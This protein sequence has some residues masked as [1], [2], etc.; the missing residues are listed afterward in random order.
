MQEYKKL[1]EDLYNGNIKPSEEKINSEEYAKVR[2]ESIELSNKILNGLN[3]QNKDIYYKYIELQS[4]LQSMDSEK[5]FIEGFSLAV[6]LIVGSL[7]V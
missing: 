4:Q 1:L 3:N 2:K 7:E 6:K 5:Q